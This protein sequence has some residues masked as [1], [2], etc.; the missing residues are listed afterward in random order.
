MH[1]Q[2]LQYAD[3]VLSTCSENQLTD[4]AGN[5]STASNK[6]RSV[7]LSVMERNQNRHSCELGD[8]PLPFLAVVKSD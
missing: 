6:S 2:G 5:S 3:G 8:F 1:I 7:K 4:L